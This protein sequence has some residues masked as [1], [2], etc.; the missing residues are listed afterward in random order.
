MA[1]SRRKRQ[2]EANK[3]SKALSF[4]MIFWVGAAFCFW[5]FVLKGDLI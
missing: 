1:R 2:D 3:D 5:L 4:G